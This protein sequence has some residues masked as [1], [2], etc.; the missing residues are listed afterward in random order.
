M[1]LSLFISGNSLHGL[2]FIF[3][4]S[5]QSSH[6]LI[7]LIFDLGTFL[8]IDLD[9]IQQLCFIRHDF[10]VECMERCLIFNSHWVDGSIV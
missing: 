5:I 6:I 10:A 8:L 1:Q 7:E 4:H 9:I 3:N 2:I